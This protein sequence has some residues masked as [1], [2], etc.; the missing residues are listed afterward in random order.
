MNS[1]TKQDII[2]WV[3]S[4]QISPDVGVQLLKSVRSPNE[5]VPATPAATSADDAVAHKGALDIAVIGLAGRYPGAPDVRQFWRN[6]AAGAASIQTVPP[7]RWDADAIYH[8]ESREGYTSVS[9][10]GGF[11]DGIDRFDSLFFNISPREAELMDPQQRLFLQE[12]WRALEDA[13]YHEQNLDGRK[14]GVFVGCKSGDYQTLLD[15]GRE[16]EAAFI[17]VG[18]NESILAARIAY[19]LNLRGPALAIDTACSSS[20]VAIHLAC[21]SLLGGTCEMAIAGGAALLATPVFHVL[22]S[23]AGML[24]NS[25]RCKTFD[26][27]ADGFVPGEGIGVVVLK[28]LAAALRDKD[29]IYAVIK[30]SGINQDGR[31]NG[32]TAPSAPSQT[33][34]ERD[35]YA[36][37]GID[38]DTLSYIEAHGTGTKLGDPI[39][40]QALTDSF[41]GHTKRRR[42]CAIGSVKTNIGHTL[43][44][45]GIAGFTKLL[46][47][48]RHRQ[49][50]SSLNFQNENEHIA[51]EDSPFFVNR[52]LRPWNAEGPQPRRAAISAFGF[53]GTNA[54]IVVEESSVPQARPERSA[55]RLLVV[56]AK[57]EDALRRRAGHLADWF[58]SDEGA[59]A[60][61][62]DVIYTLLARRHHF[63]VRMAFIVGDAKNAVHALRALAQGETRVVKLKQ[64][65]SSV[66]VIAASRFEHIF[67]RVL[68][69]QY[70]AE[71]EWH[72]LADAFLD[73]AE[74]SWAQLSVLD[75]RCVSLPVYPFADD[76][77]WVE[78]PANPTHVVTQPT[79]LHPLVH[80][81]VSTLQ[82]QRYRSEFRGDEFFLRDH[83]VAGQRVLPG[84]A[85]LEFARVA[86][87]LAAQRPITTIRQVV[88]S[89]PATIERDRLVLELDLTPETDLARFSLTMPAAS[90]ETV[91]CCQGKLGW[92]ERPVRAP[93]RIDPRVLRA[94]LGALRPGEQCY[95]QFRNMGLD[96]GPGLRSI[97]EVYPGEQE[98]LTR[99]EVPSGVASQAFALHPSLLDG[100]LQSLIG[101]QQPGRTEHATYV[102]FSLEEAVIHGSVPARCWAHVMRVGAEQAGSSGAVKFD[103]RIADEAGEVKVELK[104]LLMRRL[105]A[106][107]ATVTA[108]SATASVCC[109]RTDWVPTTEGVS[110]ELPR[111][112]LL[113]AS[114]DQARTAYMEQQ[115]Q[116][117]V[118]LVKPGAEFRYWAGQTYTID[119]C[120]PDH[121]RA[122]LASMVARGMAPEWIVHAW[123]DGMDAETPPP[124]ALGRTIESMLLLTQAL[125]ANK[126][127][128]AHICFAHRS[129]GSDK[130]DWLS[131]SGGLARSVMAEQPSMQIAVVKVAPESGDIP[132]SHAEFWRRLAQE[133]R[134]KPDGGVVRWLGDRRET[135][136]ATAASIDSGNATCPAR[137]GGVYWITGGLG[138]IGRVLAA[139]LAR[140][141]KVTVVLSG[142]TDPTLA[143]EAWM[144]QFAGVGSTVR[145]LRADVTDRADVERALR[146]IRSSHGGL[147]GVMHAAGITRDARVA[148]KKLDDAR[149][150]IAPKVLGVLNLDEVTR[151]EPLDFFV[152]CAA[153]AGVVG[154]AGQADYAYG[155]AFLD[156]FA[157]YRQALA[158][159]G[160]RRGKTVA[161]DWPLWREGGMRMNAATEQLLQTTLGMVPLESAEALAVLANCLEGPGGQTI[162]VKADVARAARL[163]G[164]DPTIVQAAR[165][166][167]PNIPSERMQQP[168]EVSEV[169]VREPVSRSLVQ[170]VSSI[171]KVKE[172]DI[173]LD[174]DMSEFGFDSIG[175]TQFANRVNERYGLE[176]MPSVFFEHPTLAAFADFLCRNHAAILGR[177]HNVAPVPP[178]VTAAPAEPET[179][180]SPPAARFAPPVSK[181]E[182]LAG[183][184]APLAIIG[185][186]GRFPQSSDLQSFWEHL[187]AGHDLI[188]EVPPERWDWR[189]VFGDP[190]REPGKTNVKWGGFMPGVDEFDAA[191]FGI[192]PREA[193]LMDPQQRLFMQAV[194]AAIDNAGYRP[195]DLAGSKTS[196]YAGVTT[197]DYLELLKSHEVEIQA[198]S[199]TGVAHSI[200][201]NRISFLLNLRGP[202][203]PVDT[204]CSSA[205]V[206]IH[207]AAESIWCGDCDLAIA[208]GVNAILTPTLHI[209][210]N[211]AGMLAEDGRC[212]TF[213]RSANG[214]VRG[215]GVGVV[216][217]KPLAKALA[218]GDHVHAVLRGSSVNHGGRSNSLTAPN[219]NAQA[220]VI[221]AALERA[222]IDPDSIGYIEAHGT[223][224]SLGD[225]IEINGLK[226]AFASARTR[227]G[228]PLNTDARCAVGS[229]KSNVGH[230][231]AAAGMAGL[232]KAMLA[233][234]NERVPATLHVKE[235]NPYLELAGSGLHVAR[236]AVPWPVQHDQ[237]GAA[238]PRRAGISS[239][240]FGGVN[241]H[242][243]IEDFMPSPVQAMNERPQ[244]VVLSAR[245]GQR[246]QVYAATLADHLDAVRSGRVS[247]RGLTLSRLAYTL[248][249]GREAMTERLAFVAASLSDV[250]SKLRRFAERGPEAFDDGFVGSGGSQRKHVGSVLDG[251]E[252]SEFLRLLHQRG[253]LD[254]LAQL[255]TSGV[256]INWSVCYDGTRPQRV[257]LPGYPFE[258]TRF[259]IPS[260]PRSARPDSLLGAL[261]IA[262]SSGAGL[263][264]ARTLRPLEALVDHHRVA[265][266]AIL[267]AAAYL[268]MALQAWAQMEGD[269]P[270]CVR[271]IAWLQPLVIDDAPVASRFHLERGAD[272]THFE[273]RSGDENSVHCRGEL[274]SGDL[275]D[276]AQLDLVEVASRCGRI[277]PLDELRA[278][279]ARQGIDYG[280][281]YQGLREVR[282]GADEALGTIELP[283]AARV[284]EGRCILHPG[285]MD[286][287]LQTIA[288]LAT[289]NE[290][291]RAWLPFSAG[292]VVVVRSPGRNVRAYVKRAGGQCYHVALLDADGRVCVR[293]TDLQLRER[294]D[295]LDRFFYRPGWMISAA[296]PQSQETGAAMIVAS[297]STEGLANAL[298]AALAQ[299]SILRFDVDAAAWSDLE[300][301]LL[302][303]S[304][305]REIFFIAAAH[306]GTEPLYSLECLQVAQ[307][308]GVHALLQIVQTIHRLGW[309][310]RE[311]TLVIATCG[312]HAVHSGE[313]VRPWGAELVGFG[314]SLA[315]EYPRW[316]VRCVDLSAVEN[317]DASAD[318]LLREPASPAAEESAWREGR[319]F[320][321][322]MEA[323][324]LGVAAPVYRERG[325]YLLLGGAGGLG[326]EYARH[327]AVTVRARVALVGRGELSPQ[328]Q[329]SLAEIER[330][331][332]EGLY[333]R[334]DITDAGSMQRAVTEIEARFGQINGVVHTAIVLKDSTIERLDDETLAD[335]LAPKAAGSVVLAQLFA[336]RALDFVLFFSSAQSF[337]GNAGQANYAAGCTFKDAYAA[338]LRQELRCPVK[339]INWGYWGSVGVVSTDRYQRELAQRGVQSITTAEGMQAVD[340]FLASSL[341]QV[342]AIKAEPAALIAMGIDLGVRRVAAPEM[343]PSLTDAVADEPALSSVSDVEH[344]NA[345]VS[346]QR[347][348]RWARELAASVLREMPVFAEPSATRSI[349]EWGQRAGITPGY[350]RLWR[351]LVRMLG[352]HGD[353]E[354]TGD[355]AT[356]LELTAAQRN[357]R[358]REA[359]AA[360]KQALLATHPE[361]AAF[362]RLL[363]TCVPALPEVL[364]GRRS[365]MEVMFP[366][367]SMELV[368]AIYR[369]NRLQDACN[370]QVA[371]FVGAYVAR[372][373]RDD[374]SATV[375][376]LE[377]GAGT[378]G[379]SKSVLESLRAYADRVQF[380]YTDVSLGFVGFGERT[381]GPQHPFSEFK[382]LDIERLPQAQG[383]EPGSCD[384]IFA[385]NVLHATR[386]IG[387]TLAHLKTLLKRNGAVVIN[388]LTQAQDFGTLTFG[389]TDGWWLFED[390]EQRVPDS[391][392]LDARLW[393]LQLRLAGFDRVRVL[394]AE[395]GD[396]SRPQSII[397]AESDG[398]VLTSADQN[399]T[400]L[401]EVS[402]TAVTPVKKSRA[403]LAAPSISREAATVS[404][405]PSLHAREYLRE[406][407]ARVLKLPK[408][409]LSG[410]ETF[411]RFGVD[412]LVVLQLNEQLEKDLGKLPT[413]L[414][415]EYITIDALAD[416]LVARYPDRLRAIM[417]E[418]AAVK[419]TGGDLFAATPSTASSPLPSEQT[420][421][422]AITASHA[423]QEADSTGDLSGED[424][425]VVG[426]SGR[427]PLAETI[428]ELWANLR[429]GR[430]CIRDVPASRWDWRQWLDAS[431]AAE[432]GIYTKAGGFIDGVDL[433][434]P[435]FFQLPPKEAERIDPQER[436]FLQCAFE[437]LEDA[438]LS[439]SVRERLG[440]RVGVFVGAMNGGYAGRSPAYWS[441]ANRVSY[442]FNLSGPSFAVD[443]ACSSSLTAIHLA[444]ESL[445]RGE[446][447]AALAGG[448]NVIFGPGHFRDRCAVGMLSRTDAC[449]AFG[450][451]ADGFVTGEG[452]GAVL[453]MPKA[454]AKATGMRILGLIK[455][456]AVNAGGKTSGYTVPNPHAQAGVVSDALSRAGID[457]ATISYI[458]AH[459]TGTA[460][461]DPIEIGGLQRVF[462][463]RA[464]GAS[465]AIGSVKSNI[466]HLE[467]AAG[468][469]ALT[470][471]LLQIEHGELVPSLHASP[472]NAHIRFEDTP[473]RVQQQ[474]APWTTSEN[475]PR[476]ACVSSFGAGGANAHIVVEEYQ[477]AVAKQ[478]ANT[479]GPL[480]FI[481]CAKSERRLRAYANRLADYLS[482]R[483]AIDLRDIA[484]TLRRRETFEHCAVVVAMDVGELVRK[485]R[486]CANGQHAS[487]DVPAHAHD[488]VI[489][490][491]IWLP[492][493]PFETT[494]LWSEP[495]FSPA[496]AT[497]TGVISAS[498][499]PAQ[500]SD[501]VAQ[502]LRRCLTEQLGCDGESLPGSQ[503]FVDLGV[504][505]IHA[506][507]LATRLS[508]ALRADITPTVFLNFP[509]LGELES[510]LRGATAAQPVPSA[511]SERIE[512]DRG[513][514]IAVIGVSGRFPGAD[515]VEQFWANL[516]DGRESVREIPPERW[517]VTAL[518]DARPNQP[519]KTV[520]KWAGLIDGVEFFDPQ[521]FDLL[522]ME[523]KFIDPQQRLFLEEAWRALESAGCTAQRLTAS[524]CGVFVGCGTGDYTKV[525]G[526]HEPLNAFAMMGNHSAVL[527]AR[528]SYFLN[529][530]GPAV[531]I[532]TAC[533]SSLVAIHQACESLLR[534]E[535]D[536]AVAG[537]VHLTLTP[538]AQVLSS[539]AGMLSPDGKC[540]TFDDA[541]NGIVIGEAVGAVV[542]KPRARAEADG[543]RILAV[544]KGSGVN[545]DGRTH[546]MASP[547]ANAQAALQADIYEKTGIN[548]ETITYVETHGTGTRLG[549]PVEVEALTQ[550]FRKFT[551]KRG[552]CALASVKP[553]I[554]HAYQAAGVASFIKAVLAL[555]HRQIPPSLHVSR[556]NKYLRLDASPF[557]VNTSLNEWTPPN[558]TPRRAAVSSFG[559][560]GTNAHVVLEEF[561]APRAVS[562]R[563]SNDPQMILLSART[564]PRLRAYV[565]ELREYL[566]AV[567]TS[568]RTSEM[569][570]DIAH[571]LRTG[572]STYS[573]R[574]ALVVN[575]VDDLIQALGA[576][577]DHLSDSERIVFARGAAPA[578]APTSSRGNSLLSFARVWTQGAQ[579]DWEDV[580]GVTPGQLVPLPLPP[581]LRV[582]CWP[583]DVSVVT[584]HRHELR[585]LNHEDDAV[586]TNAPAA[587]RTLI[588]SLDTEPTVFLH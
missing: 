551:D 118:L 113:F 137:D 326:L 305:V 248:Q 218:D 35:V 565:A 387:R 553:N 176:L 238:L 496:V 265:G 250:S 522:A 505:S 263:Q 345:L 546:G 270:A 164:A 217:L 171:L 574:L 581:L 538:L 494:R 288:G 210:F 289:A 436:L 246:L 408:S 328:K 381:F 520:S 559:Y 398:W 36:R 87:E 72:E 463:V 120:N 23:K 192:S 105:N 237:S 86:G 392:V 466:G 378:G 385:S 481:L 377:I 144:N 68:G 26:N 570:R 185:V 515:D 296:A 501:H 194:W 168:I 33:A 57:N 150:V 95:E 366:G 122:L 479:S 102:P 221:D 523:A 274:D 132:I 197:G 3:K 519:G 469:V 435:S 536:L 500:P 441:I 375:R 253:R 583:T 66:P 139:W 426:V 172:K 47:Q 301:T 340:R 104:G 58:E 582:R 125:I 17:F 511:P 211:R 338:A 15:I 308:R 580:P 477:P 18:N 319:R 530:R 362:V 45:A 249:V 467:A 310:E 280:E 343:I 143:D 136:R 96:Y 100:A 20:L 264:W 82:T 247:D 226:K 584:S 443:S 560:S 579:V 534:G 528:L 281:F 42:Y 254:K 291:S 470:K 367:G 492:A 149:A 315:K 549:D 402:R 510:H 231:E 63:P 394:G 550:S 227:A 464:D 414:L 91:V 29:Q 384:L 187:V 439:A 283:E 357:A 298:T 323:I 255:W 9:K 73:G 101:V 405:D 206:A 539:S 327:L 133:A 224:T 504:D 41:R 142:R 127:T 273:I 260:T 380:V 472:P 232:F 531:A 183:A 473:F 272:G 349:A 459:G 487:A 456:S 555:Q 290:A 80:S 155:N 320:V 363:E 314:K 148:D 151:D 198:Q 525:I 6:L 306:A 521:F 516:R 115:P 277:I 465:C 219:P 541:A 243:I 4:R 447:A 262:G 220:E 567:P 212:K 199:S 276:D 74:P 287:A 147:N 43:A 369:G 360:E 491:P 413:T 275:P 524:R 383:F 457:P 285:L 490:R 433:F 415:F 540:K 548:P 406:V 552:Y 575:S 110:G 145:W 293:M 92:A 1:L 572:R 304:S 156:Q 374:P 177:H 109:F 348:Q 71:H 386:R 325:V 365:H 297:S 51:F 163:L 241:A 355:R 334:A 193:E 390:E 395:V 316:N 216:I 576:F 230:L 48:L 585:P 269:Q 373:L 207:R 21:E 257:P 69:S 27:A 499:T 557:F 245:S 578:S 411:E 128:A 76:R 261:S 506:T 352:R 313:S 577:R 209:G 444:C 397:V 586:V 493:C 461:G 225:P 284:F 117:K 10:W 409:S 368:E 190:A 256:E 252:G 432:Q 60:D 223:G 318:A 180:P 99:L 88:W 309:R 282:V 251:D 214:Y 268:E 512:A 111:S 513:S 508:E 106:V 556:T 77:H 65:R 307:R 160:L 347:L 236:E 382:A 451:G 292:E 321:R 13:G 19:L 336:H 195:G 242:V 429:A 54:H 141:T 389:L 55:L 562:L 448:V 188:T 379:T 372:R 234:Q 200:L 39:E 135:L 569:L 196:L 425:A 335:V 453:L 5:P 324:R 222:G 97:V 342:M 59:A 167:V 152:L 300:R 186:S 537:G 2:G 208:G 79:A 393:N 98:T 558:G 239:F 480:S 474:L 8:P 427:Y 587:L 542:L 438:G 40:V 159:R 126:Q 121:Y 123:A 22:A 361:L 278:G 497:A 502:Q 388:E 452:V 50:V 422:V 244:L 52:E 417:P 202:S 396:A 437:T 450:E 173:D 471:V 184:R 53:S 527:P 401:T 229:V 131:P 358:T 344:E 84:V 258:P 351:A 561:V 267:P 294:R 544:I 322:Y 14:C 566:L 191:F 175:L 573:V 70:I 478:P 49:L 410:G 169:D 330:S 204:A 455:A 526:E 81:N 215:E 545:Q 485:L 588:E 37:S 391:P 529:L 61:W 460:L 509:T 339:V 341:D 161:L 103:V 364:T 563:V 440:R 564:E 157:M 233:L 83:V 442:H 85:Y 419:R 431:G 7:E 124:L 482:E 356:V 346:L 532:D 259:W 498:A 514:D 90:G 302:E 56:S 31:T 154:N 507:R 445:R 30:G 67:E 547:N 554:G 476:R 165:S 64:N 201:V 371:A 119:P 424:I 488:Q 317:I 134:A 213:D 178:R 75:V 483:D 34:L 153:L 543:D 495:E 468:I 116:A 486:A 46:L 114:S 412:S 449:R 568:A 112:L 12:A 89:R 518:Y 312:A 24:S 130:L 329:S 279:Y 428:A 454:R 295:A 535:S 94:R 205:L 303:N 158:Q 28:P 44:A 407:F 475:L 179:Q 354:A 376:I 311:L 25:D 421:N 140:S 404:I 423:T 240:G 418:V 403:D 333:V 146:E 107:A 162:I 166:V 462:G 170:I 78:Q 138:G 503:P 353:V 299:R 571:T 533:S 271:N 32:I 430:H 370:R 181:P 489:G 350:A 446:C 235:L 93:D 399:A 189:A 182:I 337:A 400:P 416:H 62:N 203:E 332:G 331:G 16:S 458:E 108:N 174:A 359:I 38:P 420:Q 484:E 266:T 286:A 129:Q 11:I 434:D 517:D 228:K